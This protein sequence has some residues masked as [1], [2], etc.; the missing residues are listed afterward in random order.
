MSEEK[1]NYAPIFG[2]LAS[3]NDKKRL[4]RNLIWLLEMQKELER[5]K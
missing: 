1:Q 2:E 4:A 5:V 3:Y